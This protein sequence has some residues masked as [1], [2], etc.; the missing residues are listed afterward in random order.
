MLSSDH[1]DHLVNEG[2]MFA[3]NVKKTV[4]LNF[5]KITSYQQKPS[6]LIKNFKF[7]EKN[8]SF[9]LPNKNNQLLTL[10]LMLKKIKENLPIQNFKNA[11][12]KTIKL[13]DKIEKKLNY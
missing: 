1:K 12:L 4:D 7:F 8:K 11:N 6:K 5:S 2:I 3:Q 10:D 13:L 9:N